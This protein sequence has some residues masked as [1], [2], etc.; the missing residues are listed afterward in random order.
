MGVRRAVIVAVASPLFAS[1]MLAGSAAPANA[2]EPTIGGGGVKTGDVARVTGNG[3]KA[4]GVPR[5]ARLL[6][7]GKQVARGKGPLSYSFSTHSVPNGTYEASLQT[8]G[9]G[10]LWSTR[11]KTT[12]RLKAAPYTPSGVTAHR[13]GHTVSVRWSRGSEPDLTSYRVLS[14]AGSGIRRSEGAACSGSS[15]SATLHLPS[16]GAGRYGFA[17]RAYRSDG[18]GGTLG[19]PASSMHYVRLPEPRTE[20]TG[21]RRTPNGQAGQTPSITNTPTA[22]SP[23]GGYLPRGIGNSTPYLPRSNERS[24]LKLPSVGP[25]GFSYPKPDQ[26]QVAPPSGKNRRV[27]EPSPTS[28]TTVPPFGV[29]V[30]ATLGG[31]LV[32]A[33]LLARWRLRMAVRAR[34]KAGIRAAAGGGH[35]WETATAW[36]KSAARRLKHVYHRERRRH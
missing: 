1:A 36:S 3:G 13:S 4:L 17:V 32:L 30:A 5:L 22:S 25:S 12:L 9:V 26:P 35:A 16:N 28:L 29:G 23:G 27:A 15:C 24:P 8:S 6:L 11:G 21:A 20:R 7:R 14:T 34:E 2:S 33:H 19:S 10:L 18:S 31:L